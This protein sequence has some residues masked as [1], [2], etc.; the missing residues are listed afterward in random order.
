MDTHKFFLVAHANFNGE[1]GHDEHD[2][3]ENT[4]IS[5]WMNIVNNNDPVESNKMTGLWP[6][7][8][9]SH[10]HYAGVR[11]KVG[12]DYVFLRDNDIPLE[13]YPAAVSL[14]FSANAF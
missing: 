10:F 9:S 12:N 6:P 14:A 5:P 4:K 1:M 8:A 3:T 13:D 11:Y 7:G 2:L